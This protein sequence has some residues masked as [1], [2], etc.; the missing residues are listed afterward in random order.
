[1]KIASGALAALLIAGI[2]WLPPVHAQGVPQG[3]YLQSCGNVGMDV[4]T[5]VASCRAR[6]GRERHAD[7]PEVSRCVGDIGNDNGRLQCNYGGGGPM[8]PQLGHGSSR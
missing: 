6:D 7:L 8:P 3:T 2:A 1:M 5:L 4:D